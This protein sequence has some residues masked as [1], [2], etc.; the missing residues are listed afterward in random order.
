MNRERN[1]QNDIHI[2]ISSIISYYYIIFICIRPKKIKKD[3]ILNLMYSNF[4]VPIILLW[5]LI[6]TEDVRNI[7][8]GSAILYLPVI[9]IYLKES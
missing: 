3:T 1:N 5:Y 8:M 2:W 6:F 9:G 4:A 7:A